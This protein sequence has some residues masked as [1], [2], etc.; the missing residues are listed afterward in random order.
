[1]PCILKYK[2]VDTVPCEKYEEP[3]AAEI[4]ETEAAIDRHMDRMRKVMPM[5]GKIKEDHK[6]HTWSGIVAC[7]ACGG[8]LHL[9]HAGCNGHVWGKCETKDCVAWIE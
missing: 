6:G 7:P 1:M 9:S 4:A 8:K 5:I 2:A 3:S